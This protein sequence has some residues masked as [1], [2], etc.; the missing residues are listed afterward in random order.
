MSSSLDSVNRGTRGRVDLDQ[1][2]EEIRQKVARAV[3]S[4][5]DIVFYFAFLASNKARVLALDITALI[6]EM[7]TSAEG[8][9]IPQ[10]EVPDEA[11]S[12]ILA[13][14][15][16]LTKV[17]NPTQELLE[18]VVREGSSFSKKYLVPNY[19]QGTRFQK[20]GEEAASDLRKVR[21]ALVPKWGVL[22]SYM[23][24]LLRKNPLRVRDVRKSAL[25]VATKGLQTTAEMRLPKEKA[26]TYALQ[27][28][29]GV[30]AVSAL[31]RE[32]DLFVRASFPQGGSPQGFSVKEFE[33]D[34][35]FVTKLQILDLA[36][37]VVSPRTLGIKK[38][39]VVKWLGVDAKVTYAGDVHFSVEPGLLPSGA[40]PVLDV[41]SGPGD[42]YR[43]SRQLLDAAWRS[44]PSLHAMQ[45]ALGLSERNPS[46]SGVV[47]LA[48]F[49]GEVAA[50]LGGVSTELQK[51][52]D[53]LG[54]TVAPR[55]PIADML[56]AY[57][58][59]FSKDTKAAALDSIS[60]LEQEGYKSAAEMLVQGSYD[61]FFAIGVESTSA[62]RSFGAAAAQFNAAIGS[63][64]HV[65]IRGRNF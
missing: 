38:N 18:Q 25:Q 43:S 41:L 57:N 47:T 1:R 59:L 12:G 37:N 51:T 14:V 24:S 54:V 62:S 44:L 40:Q 39:D 60:L 11:Y 26:S 13:A 31:G 45:D 21:Q 20:K 56:L 35:G 8:Q 53:R 64:V 7:L 6:E 36:K 27:F 48:K 65:G 10:K 32:M 4:D 52:L 9:R 29:A 42:A 17:Y 23:S 33:V 22:P 55:T 3:V 19:K 50:T 28:I 16:A 49:F 34:S 63:T 46:A 2:W 5:P 61:A 30:A 15:D 58:P